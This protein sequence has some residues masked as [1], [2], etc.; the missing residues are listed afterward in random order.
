[1]GS[2]LFLLDGRNPDWFRDPLTCTRLASRRDVQRGA[3]RDEQGDGKKGSEHEGHE[4]I[5]NTRKDVLS[6]SRLSCVSRSFAP[7]VFQIALYD[8][9]PDG[10][11]W[12]EKRRKV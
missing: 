6:A 9:S 12:L 5:R 4:S 11:K 8:H 3:A 2:T 10:K 7:F 1:M